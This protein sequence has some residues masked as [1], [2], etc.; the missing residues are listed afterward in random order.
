[1]AEVSKHRGFSVWLCGERHMHIRKK[2][3]YCVMKIVGLLLGYD[4]IMFLS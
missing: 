1:M 4:K 2:V 3:L